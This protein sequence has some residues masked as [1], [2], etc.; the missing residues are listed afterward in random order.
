[1]A[2]EGVRVSS[3]LIIKVMDKTAFKSYDILSFTPKVAWK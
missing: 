2:G 1:M 3:F